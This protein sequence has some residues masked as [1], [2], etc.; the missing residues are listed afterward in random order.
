MTITKQDILDYTTH[1]ITN[2][3]N[4]ITVSNSTLNA[5]IYDIKHNIQNDT[6]YPSGSQT[7]NQKIWQTIETP[8]DDIANVLKDDLYI[9]RLRAYAKSEV[10]INTPKEMLKLWPHIYT[11][12]LEWKL[13]Y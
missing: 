7:P 1:W 13:F 4:K 12:F 2:K 8:L 5:I 3:V 9:N 6:E 10:E 11:D